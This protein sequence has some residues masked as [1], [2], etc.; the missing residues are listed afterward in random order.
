MRFSR[1][2]E[3][4]PHGDDEDVGRG[5]AAGDGAGRENGAETRDGE[6]EPA[7][8]DADAG[9][10][11]AAADSAGAGAEAD[12]GRGR[13]RARLLIVAALV[14]TVV[15]AAVAGVGGWRWADLHDSG[16]ADSN[17]A[18]VDQAETA[19]VA[20]AAQAIIEGVFSYD[21][22]DLESYQSALHQYLD[23]EMLARYQETAEQNVQIITQAKTTI[24]ATVEEDDV[25]VERI[26]G[27][28]ATAL[29][30]MS[31]TGN[32]GG[33]QQISDAAPL[34]VRMR[35]IDGHWKADA[36]SLL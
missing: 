4:G 16:A 9:T 23:E 19:E 33:S 18:F 14:G 20:S 31:R 17:T 29:A 8:G 3:D 25:G 7:G 10:G 35:N 24:T 34:R 12:A 27:D 5:A 30:I 32:N 21:Y 13:G 2:S 36:I 22:Q 28:T 1:K 6:A 15:F 26:D 11:A